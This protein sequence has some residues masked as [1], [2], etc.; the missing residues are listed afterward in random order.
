MAVH[1]CA[2][3]PTWLNRKE[4]SVALWQLKHLK[5]I[6]QLIEEAKAAEDIQDEDSKVSQ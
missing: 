4:Q 5:L 6:V 3:P 1:G 2:T